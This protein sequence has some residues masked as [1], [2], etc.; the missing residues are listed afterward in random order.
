MFGQYLRDLPEQITQR[1][2]NPW[3]TLAQALAQ[4]YGYGSLEELD[5]AFRPSVEATMAGRGPTRLLRRGR[6]T[7]TCRS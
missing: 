6:R 3:D 5:A 7:H 4:T 1:V 2:M